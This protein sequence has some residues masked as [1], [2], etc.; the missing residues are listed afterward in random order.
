MTLETP[1]LQE[2][3]TRPT[4]DK[5]VAAAT[6]RA[7]ATVLP[8]QSGRYGR[9]GCGAHLALPVV[10]IHSSGLSDI[11]QPSRSQQVAG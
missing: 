10:S 4:S 1:A 11:P 3:T 8:W 7:P 5:V 9:E 6:C 2:N